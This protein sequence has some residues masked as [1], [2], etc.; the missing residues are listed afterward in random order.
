MRT[1]A[2]TQEASPSKYPMYVKTP[3]GIE[4]RTSGGASLPGY[5][6]NQFAAERAFALHCGRK[7]K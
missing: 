3:Q 5:F 2:T 6:L 4:V 7:A 1:A